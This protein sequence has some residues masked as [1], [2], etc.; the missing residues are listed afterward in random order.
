M[1]LH[2]SSPY[3]EW[4]SVAN[5]ISSSPITTYSSRGAGKRGVDQR[6]HA[7]IY[8]G[9]HPPEKLATE[10]D[11]NKS[12][13]R[14]VPARADEKLDPKSRVNMGKIYTVE[15]NTKVKEIGQVEKDSLVKLL[16]YWKQIINT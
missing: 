12:A 6:A 9:S 5:L 14:V 11:M 8:T 15:W 16:A 7:I 10:R 3:T 1:P 2:V 13:I 4:V